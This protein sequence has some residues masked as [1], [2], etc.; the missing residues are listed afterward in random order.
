MFER[1]STNLL[2]AGQSLL[3]Q[4]IPAEL[5]VGLVQLIVDVAEVIQSCRFLK[6]GNS[7]SELSHAHIRR[8]QQAAGLVQIG[9]KLHRTTQKRHRLIVLVVEDVETPEEIKGL[10]TRRIE[11]NGFLQF[12][13]G[14]FVRTIIEVEL[15]KGFVQLC[16]IRPQ[17]KGCLVFFDG[18]ISILAEGEIFGTQFVG[19]P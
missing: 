16:L 8:T 6:S 3:R 5:S 7:I 18:C 19:S 2:R 14:V 4:L 10:G 12:T 17:L 15:S 1:A 9:L 11:R 13:L